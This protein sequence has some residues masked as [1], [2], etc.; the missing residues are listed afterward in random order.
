[1]S[2]PLVCRGVVLCLEVCHIDD[3]VGSHC[4]AFCVCMQ[5]VMPTQALR[6]CGPGDLLVAPL[7]VSKQ[8][9]FIS[10]R[11]SAVLCT[12]IRTGNIGGITGN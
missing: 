5:P 11:P 1:M 9:S 12:D 6:E 10:K 7:L 4:K 2:V 8:L 3:R